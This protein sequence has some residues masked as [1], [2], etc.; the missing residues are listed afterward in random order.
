MPSQDQGVGQLTDE[1]EPLRVVSPDDSVRYAGHVE[2]RARQLQMVP[3]ASVMRPPSLRKVLAPR[4]AGHLWTLRNSAGIT[5]ALRARDFPIGKYARR[6]ARAIASRRDALEITHVVDLEGRYRG[7]WLSLDSR[8]ML[9]SAAS[10][11]SLSATKPSVKC[12]RF[13]VCSRNSTRSRGRNK[14]G[15]K[16][17]FAPALAK[18]FQRSSIAVTAHQ[19]AN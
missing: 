12:A 1:D 3:E 15:A 5:V 18:S 13:A 10:V 16:L 8:V 17:F 19:S 11:S 14:T 4:P 9:T 6:D 2:A 7:W